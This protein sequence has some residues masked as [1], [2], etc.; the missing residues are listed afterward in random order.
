M[1]IHPVVPVL[2]YDGSNTS[3]YC[4]VNEWVLPSPTYHFLFLLSCRGGGGR[5][6]SDSIVRS[7]CD[8]RHRQNIS[9]TFK[10]ASYSRILSK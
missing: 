2:F 9:E 1:R 8:G 4:I 7:C 10:H 5:E 6:N 3:L